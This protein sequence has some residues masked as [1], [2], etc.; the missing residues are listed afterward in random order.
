MCATLEGITTGAGDD[1]LL[2]IPESQYHYLQVITSVTGI[3]AGLL[4]R[5]IL[6]CFTIL[7]WA[8]KSLGRDHP[9]SGGTGMGPIPRFHARRKH[10]VET[11]A[12]GIG[13]TC[14]NDAYSNQR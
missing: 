13:G 8:T 11:C 7:P 6:K 4:E 10:C 9:R 3:T 12:L 14:R 5:A 1:I 2:T